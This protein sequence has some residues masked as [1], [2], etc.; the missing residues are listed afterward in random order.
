MVRLA[1]FAS[2]TGLRKPETAT[3]AYRRWN[4]ARSHL[5]LR[6]LSLAYAAFFVRL[7]RLAPTVSAANA[8]SR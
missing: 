2:K 4:A 8:P 3:P 5:G 1:A 6:A 7:R